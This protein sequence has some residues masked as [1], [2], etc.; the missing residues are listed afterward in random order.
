MI[1]SHATYGSTG[2]ITTLLSEKFQESGHEVLVCYGFNEGMPLS[3]KYIKL[4]FRGEIFLASKIGNIIGIH[5]LFCFFSTNKLKKIVKSYKPDVVQLFNLHA[6]YIDDLKLL[7]YLK[8]KRIKTVYTMFDEYAYMGK[9]CFSYECDKFTS[10]CHDC[11]HLKDY[12]RSSFFDK[13]TY[14]FE[15]KK[16][17][18]DKS[19]DLTFVG[20]TFVYCRSKVSA[21]LKNK[22]VELIEEP[23]DYDNMYYP[24]STDDLRQ[25]LN[26]PS[27]NIVILTI[28]NFGDVRKGGRFFFDLH[29]RMKGQTGY[30]YVFVGYDENVFGKKDGV[31]TI[32]YVK[33]KDELAEYYSLAD[34]FVF[35]SLA[36]SSPNTVQQALGCGSPVC[37]FN[38][39][40]ISTMGISDNKV[41]SLSKTKDVECLKS[42]VLQYGKKDIDT[43]R[44][45][46]GS[47]YEKY[48]ITSIYKKYLELY[49]R[50]VADS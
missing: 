13:S 45:C 25:R 34:V 48:S 49:R 22:K 20:G 42:N 10:Y 26:I 35:T 5:G 38:I 41:L 21:L 39:E 15:K 14:Y 16:N 28:T 6:S 7:E 24:R 11:T 27:G 1:N 50:I 18:Y 40:G 32:P 12:P 17:I 23:I 33:D 19:P 43:I 9:C 36:D 44:K 31:I 4:T 29:E 3:T 30:S 8:T 47:V 2:G 46:R 37:A